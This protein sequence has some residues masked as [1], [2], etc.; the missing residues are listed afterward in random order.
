ME[1]YSIEL[2]GK[3][4]NLFPV[5]D[6]HVGSKQAKLSF[7]QRVVDMIKA[8]PAARWVG[9]GDL[10]ENALIGSKSDVYKQIIPPKEQMDSIVEMLEP[11]KEKGLF[12]IAG[13]HEQRTM[14]VAGIEPEAYI[15]TRLGLPFLGFSV[16]ARFKLKGAHNGANIFTAYFH[17]NYGG[18]GSYGGKINR[19]D[20]LRDICPT[21]DAV[22]SGHF[23]ITSR[24]P[25]S[26]FEWGDTV[27]HK[28]TGYDYITGSAL[29]WNESYAE[30]KP[31][32]PSAVEHVM[33]RF[34]GGN[35]TRGIDDRTQEYRVITDS[36]T[37]DFR[38]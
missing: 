6:W 26:W 25:V 20:K 15:A 27:V 9:M 21:V 33:V 23:H 29:T 35:C 17:H 12:L 8:N 32:P 24:I 1:T 28:R 37:I 18:G 14:R 36:P 19:A 30:E 4:F 10:M 16:M 7:I 34:T 31:V 13:N 22:F 5:G 38:G 2:P 3:S 11:I